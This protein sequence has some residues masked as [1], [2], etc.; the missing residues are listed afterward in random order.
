MEIFTIKLNELLKENIITKKALADAVGASKALVT[1]WT[2]GKSLPSLIYLIKI[3]DY[4]NV[5]ID[6]LAGREDESGTKKY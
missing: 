4:F 5:S 1:I 3:A 6:Y 2:Q